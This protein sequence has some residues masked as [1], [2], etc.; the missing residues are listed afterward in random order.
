VS[1]G[2]EKQQT[3]APDIG[4][5]E[6]SALARARE[7]SRSEDAAHEPLLTDEELQMLLGDDPPPG[8]ARKG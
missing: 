1:P 2:S 7:P 6:K 5:S 3:S 4:G 8:N